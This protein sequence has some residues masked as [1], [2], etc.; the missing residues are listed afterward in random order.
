VRTKQY[1]SLHRWG[2]VLHPWILHSAPLNPTP[3]TPWIHPSSSALCTPESATMRPL[4]PSPSGFTTLHPWI[5]YSASHGST[6]LWTRHS[7]PLNPLC[8]TPTPTTSTMCVSQGQRMGMDTTPFL[9]FSC[10]LLGTLNVIIRQDKQIW[11]APFPTWIRWKYFTV[12]YTVGR[13][14]STSVSG[15]WSDTAHAETVFGIILWRRH[16]VFPSDIYQ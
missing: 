9:K 16:V 2:P 10:K 13:Q 14:G 15:S 12:H 8:R 3:F 11:K 4:D 6:P 7:A 1:L 5:R